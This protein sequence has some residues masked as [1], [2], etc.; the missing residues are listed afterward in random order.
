MSEL[1]NALM[2]GQGLSADEADKAIE[3]MRE[4][5]YEGEDPEEL[6]YDYGMEPDYIFDII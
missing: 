2:S 6:L 1:K 4:A 3:E 5:V